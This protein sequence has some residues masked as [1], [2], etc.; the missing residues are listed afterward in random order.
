MGAGWTGAMQT[1][2]RPKGRLITTHQRKGGF[3][4]RDHI[5]HKERRVFDWWEAAFLVVFIFLNI[6]EVGPQMSNLPVY[7]W[8]VKNALYA[9][10]GGVLG[11]SHHGVLAHGHH[12][13]G[14]HKDTNGEG[15]TTKIT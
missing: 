5:D 4:H 7:N 9:L 11:H 10:F 14:Q 15:L 13:H 12:A 6:L 1:A 2:S 8:G 3:N